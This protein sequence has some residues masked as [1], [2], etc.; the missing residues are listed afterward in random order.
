MHPE[1]MIESG[2]Y[3]DAATGDIWT[4]TT[5]GNWF[6]NGIPHKPFPHSLVPEQ[7]RR[8]TPAVSIEDAIRMSKEEDK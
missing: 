8:N 1:D 2:T 4:K 6:V 5:A 3:E 7:R